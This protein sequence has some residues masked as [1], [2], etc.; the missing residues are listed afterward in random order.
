MFITQNPLVYDNM[1]DLSSEKIISNYLIG[2]RSLNFF[3]LYYHIL[4][5]D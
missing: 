5:Y 4:S 1:G 3:V 2:N